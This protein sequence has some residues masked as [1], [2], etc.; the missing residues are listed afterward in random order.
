MPD[1]TGV[2]CWAAVGSRRAEVEGGEVGRR[3]GDKRQMGTNQA[4][5]SAIHHVHGLLHVLREKY[6]WQI[7][8]IHNHC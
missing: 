6:A 5:R 2:V 3:G 7:H 4:A 1:G 8:M